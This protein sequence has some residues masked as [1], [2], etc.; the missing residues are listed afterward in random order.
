MSVNEIIPISDMSA[1]Q[2]ELKRKRD[3][4]SREQYVLQKALK[5]FEQ[6]VEQGIEQGIKKGESKWRHAEALEIA[7][8]MKKDRFSIETI[9]KLTKLSLEEIQAL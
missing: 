9:T 4:Y 8:E 6:G 7:L 1:Y 5:Q 2:R 3:N